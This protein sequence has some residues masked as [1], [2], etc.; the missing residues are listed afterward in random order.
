[1]TAQ[2]I[3]SRKLNCTVL[4]PNRYA[5]RTMVLG[6]LAVLITGFASEAAA[7]EGF[8]GPTVPRWSQESVDLFASLPVQEGGRVKPLDT[9]AQFAML[10]ING[11]RSFRTPD[12]ERIGPSEWLMDIL[13]YPEIAQ[14]YA[15]FIVNNSES[16]TAIGLTAHQER[17]DRYSYAELSQARTRLMQMAR[18]YTDIDVAYRTP[19]EQ[20]IINIAQ[21]LMQFEQMMHFLDFSDHRFAVIDEG[22]VGDTFP[23]TDGVPLSAVLQRMPGLMDTLRTE[24]QEHGDE[25]LDQEIAALSRLMSELDTVARFAQGIPLFPGLRE[26]MAEWLTPA[27]LTAAAFAFV[28]P[29]EEHIALLA[30]LESLKGQRGDR[31][32]FQ[33]ALADFHQD[34][35]SMAN[36]RGEYSKVPFEVFF[37]RW[38]FLFW[39]QWTY[40][41]CFLLATMYW[42]MPRIQVLH[43]ALPWAL[44]VPTLLLI[45]GIVLR[46]IIRGRPPVTTLYETILFITAVAVVIAI[47][48]EF[49]NRQG[50]AGSVGAFLGSFGLFLAFRYEAKEAVD[51][52]PSLVAVLDSNYWLSIHVITITIGYAGGLLAAALAH[53]YIFGKL[54]R[55]KEDNKKQYKNITRMTYGAL[56]FGLVFSVVGTIL[57][58]VWANDSWGRF[59]GWDPKENG[60]LMICLWSLV[61]LHARMGGYIRDLGIAITSII[62]GMIIVFAWW[63]VNLLGVGLHSYGFTSGIMN[64]VAIYWIVQSIVIAFGIYVWLRDTGEAMEAKSQNKDNAKQE[65]ADVQA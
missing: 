46:C 18:E 2:S 59:W 41:L 16:I 58:G 50:I 39:S 57:G 25:S 4:N 28:E 36:A 3:T 20:E 35:T 23:E 10:R 60:A 24:A 12:G 63:G 49:L 29:H 65:A 13:F 9:Y 5:W 21:N 30:K 19:V 33:A 48:I 14:H 15:T 22:I 45:I 54:F 1:M 37:Y 17:R 52:M 53:I 6:L 42:L 31:I 61:I 43:R 44:I 51:T 62:L 8:E 32:A 55:I 40:V 64:I 11:Q 56:C 7:Y 26:D 27:D 47:I 34:V 38:Q